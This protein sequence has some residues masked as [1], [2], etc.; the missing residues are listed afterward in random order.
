[1]NRSS[2][3]GMPSSR[4]PPLLFGIVCRR[5]GCGW[6]RPREQLLA[7][8]RLVHAKVARRR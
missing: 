8:E 3:V 4:S 1:M 6:V 5:T 2:T 7:E